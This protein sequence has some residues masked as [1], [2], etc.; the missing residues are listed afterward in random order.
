MNASPPI[1]TSSWPKTYLLKLYQDAISHGALRV[2]PLSQKQAKSLKASFYRLRRRADKSAANF[3]EPEFQLVT[4]TE[5]DPAT[6]CIYIVYSALPEHMALPEVTPV[7]G[8]P[9]SLAAPIPTSDLPEDLVLDTE[10]LDVEDFVS[11]L[12]RAS[13]V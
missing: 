9:A 2:G 6:G 8:V 11:S 1:S 12:R 4:A 10:E 7:E 3:I 13:D 5:W